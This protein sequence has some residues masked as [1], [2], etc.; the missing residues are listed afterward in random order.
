VRPAPGFAFFG[1]SA[2]R[3]IVAVILLL[4][5]IV[6]EDFDGLTGPSVR[7]LAEREPALSSELLVTS[8]PHTVLDLTLGN[9]NLGNANAQQPQGICHS[10]PSG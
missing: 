9:A 1:F 2:L 5:F 7:I 6:V 4:A 3:F 8:K 10:S